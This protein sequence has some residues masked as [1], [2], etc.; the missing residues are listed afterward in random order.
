MMAGL[1]AE[2]GPQTTVM[3]PLIIC[4]A[5]DCRSMD[6]GYGAD[7][8]RDA[9]KDRGYVLFRADLIHWIKSDR[10]SPQT[11]SSARNL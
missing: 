1:A 5:N 7:G 9:L 8:L 6:R 2:H 4:S 10:P 11:E 3:I